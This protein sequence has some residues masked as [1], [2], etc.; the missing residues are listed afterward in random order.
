MN[1]RRTDKYILSLLNSYL[2]FFTL[3]S[4][5]PCT[6]C[7]PNSQPNPSL[8]TL[9][10]DLGT[11]LI[12]LN[13]VCKMRFC[14]LR[15]KDT[16]YN[17]KQS[18]GFSF[19]FIS[20]APKVSPCEWSPEMKSRWEYLSHISSSSLLVRMLSILAWFRPLDLLDNIMMSR[21]EGPKPNIEPKRS[22]LIVTIVTFLWSQDVHNNTRELLQLKVRKNVDQKFAKTHLIAQLHKTVLKL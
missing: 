1:C 19:I 2:V 14:H 6:D 4:N 11:F 5:R 9:T 20:F 15:R 10:I 18:G 7:D 3:E 12:G 8:S 21:E 22:K 17:R 16:T 13:S